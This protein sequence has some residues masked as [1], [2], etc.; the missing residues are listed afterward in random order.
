MLAKIDTNTLATNIQEIGV[1]EAKSITSFDHNYD[2][3]TI[4]R[5]GGGDGMNL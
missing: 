3:I 1:F 4:A 2:E 5:G